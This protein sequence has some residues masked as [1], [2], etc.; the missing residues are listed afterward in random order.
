[1]AGLVVIVFLFSNVIPTVPVRVLLG[2]NAT[3]VQVEAMRVKE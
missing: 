2:E 1:M 3:P